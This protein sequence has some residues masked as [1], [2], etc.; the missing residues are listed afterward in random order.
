MIA[1]TPAFK[2]FRLQIIKA[3]HQKYLDTRQNKAKVQVQ[4]LDNDS[5]H[6]ETPLT[7]EEKYLCGIF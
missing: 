1:L 2:A 7:E 5:P 4:N 3:L 6:E